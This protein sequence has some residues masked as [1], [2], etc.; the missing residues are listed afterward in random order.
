[1]SYRSRA[2]V[3]L[4]A[5]AFTGASILSSGGVAAAQEPEVEVTTADMFVAAI[6][7]AQ[8]AAAGNRVEIEG[9][10]KVLYDGITG[11]ELARVPADGSVPSPGDP[12][13]RGVY[14]GPCGTSYVYVYDAV[15]D[16]NF[17]FSTGFDST[18]GSAFDFTWVASVT[19]EWSDGGFGWE[20][21][22][23]GPMWPDEHWTS[24][25]ITED[26]SAPSGTTH[27][28]EVTGS[29]VYLVN[30][31]ICWSYLPSHVATIY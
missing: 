12:A 5:L 13:A 3:G 9:S 23:W 19:A 8:A 24:G 17:R 31:T 28:A 10:S 4:A 14:A 1:M 18:K 27:I 25:W 20:F 29:T 22:D 21:E 30:G 6:D 7:D 16:N 15:G 2:S 26:T 11:E